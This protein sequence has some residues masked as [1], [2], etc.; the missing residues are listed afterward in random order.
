MSI[1]TATNTLAQSQY[2]N[3]N[4]KVA[5]SRATSEPALVRRLFISIVVLFLG[6]F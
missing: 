5:I 3:Y 6:V 1:N 2:S 4:N